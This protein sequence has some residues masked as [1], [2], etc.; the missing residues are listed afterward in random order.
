MDLNGTMNGGAAATDWLTIA[1][2]GFRPLLVWVASRYG[3]PIIFITENGVDRC[4]RLLT[5][6]VGCEKK[7]F[8]CLL[9]LIPEHAY[10][11]MGISSCGPVDKIYGVLNGW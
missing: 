1:P 2:E 5:R 4:V 11:T 9:L 8:L 7:M 3:R 10:H 6:A